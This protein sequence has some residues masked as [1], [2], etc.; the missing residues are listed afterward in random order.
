[1]YTSLIRITYFVETHFCKRLP[2]DISYYFIICCLKINKYHMYVLFLFLISLH[3]LSYQEN[4]LHG[5]PRRH[6][7]KL[8]FKDDCQF[9]Q[10][11]LDHSLPKLHNMTIEFNSSIISI[12]LNISF[13]LKKVLIY[14]FS[15]HQVSC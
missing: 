7:T 13:I 5:R 11:I 1:M 4:L 8:I 12:T 6:K 14:F 9:S 15:T 10:T 2:H 3:K